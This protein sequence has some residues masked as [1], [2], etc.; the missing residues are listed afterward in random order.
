ML[1]LYLNFCVNIWLD[2]NIDIIIWLDDTTALKGIVQWNVA[3]V[4]S[5]TNR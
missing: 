4:E 3:G 5:G 1:T 2:D